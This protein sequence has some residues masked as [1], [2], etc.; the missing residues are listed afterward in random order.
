MRT[1]L[2]VIIGLMI[3]SI[4]SILVIQPFSHSGSSQQQASV[5][6]K[7]IQQPDPAKQ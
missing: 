7:V 6:P 4:L 1:L 5:P 3:A 2:L